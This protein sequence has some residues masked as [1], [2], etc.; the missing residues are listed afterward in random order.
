MSLFL[1]RKWLLIRCT[2]L[3]AKLGINSEESGVA[4]QDMALCEKLLMQDE[5]N[6]HVWGYRHWL[7]TLFPSKKA[8][9]YDIQF[10]RKKIED[11][12][13]NYSA[14][15]FHSKNLSKKF[16][17]LALSCDKPLNFVEMIL[18]SLPLSEMQKELDLIGTGLFMQPDEN[19]VWIY[20]Q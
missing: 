13:T 2:N 10:T 18:F 16:R 17:E 4:K 20:H 12:F 14:L 7:F 1:L 11:N 8:L 15:N 19:G 6:F 5:R 3:E 9:D